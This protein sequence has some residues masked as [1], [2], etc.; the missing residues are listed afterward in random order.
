M[1]GLV[2]DWPVFTEYAEKITARLSFQRVLA[3]EALLDT[4]QETAA[5]SA[6]IAVAS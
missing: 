6:G 3:D 4:A 2:P 1:F 5:N